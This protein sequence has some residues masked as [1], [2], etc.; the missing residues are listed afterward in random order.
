MVTW[1]VC[2]PCPRSAVQ[3]SCE[4]A[5]CLESRAFDC[6][7]RSEMEPVPGRCRHWTL[8]EPRVIR[9]WMDKSKL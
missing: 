3:F 4:L 6:V 2:A 5:S 1:K 8:D 7:G 9:A